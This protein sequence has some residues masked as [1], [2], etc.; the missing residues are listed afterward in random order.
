[1]NT[2]EATEV[3]D[4][5]VWKSLVNLLAVPT[6][7]YDYATHR[8]VWG[9]SAAMDFFHSSVADFTASQL[10]RMEQAHN[11]FIEAWKAMNLQLRQ[12]VEVYGLELTLEISCKEVVPGVLPIPKPLAGGQALVK[13][14]KVRDGA[15]VHTYM[16]F[17]VLN[18]TEAYHLEDNHLRMVE[19]CDNHPM[20]QFLLDRQGLILAANKRALG[21]LREHLGS[22][23]EYTFQM[24]LSI[25]ECDGS[26]AA[27]VVFKEAQAA[28]YEQG[29]PCYRFR[30]LRWS[31]RHPGKFRWVLYE[32]WPLPDP[33]TKLKSMLVTE[34]NIS[35]FIA[36]EQT[37]R[38]QNNRLKAQLEEALT[39]RSHQPSIDID[40]PADKTLKFLDKLIQGDEVSPRE[41]FDLRD[42]ILHAADLL[43]PVNFSEQL[44]K[45]N[46]SVL[47]TEVSQ[48]LIQLLSSRRSIQVEEAQPHAHAPARVARA[49]VSLEAVSS[50]LALQRNLPDAV[51]VVLSKVD[52]WQFDSFQ[53]NVVSGGRPLS[54]LAFALLK[55]SGLVETF[56]LDEEKLVKFLMLVEDGY[57]QNPYHN[58]IHAADVLRSLHVLL[59]RGG[60]IEAGYCENQVLL[61]CYLS[62]IIHDYQH[63][64]V[65]NDF[66]V[67]SMDDLAV[68]YNDRS[69]MENHHL[70]ASFNLMQTDECNF[71][72]R[73]PPKTR[74]MTRKLT[75]DMVLAT[76]MKQHFSIH[77]MF[78]AKMH[79]HA[80]TNNSSQHTNYHA[81]PPSDEDQRSIALQ[82]T[83]KC[84]D[85]GH[86][87][88]PRAVHREWVQHLEEEFFRQGDREKQHGLAVS[89]LMDRE[90]SGVTKSQVGFIDIVALPLFQSFAHVFQGAMP[91]LEAVKDNYA[92][93]KE[94]A[95]ATPNN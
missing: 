31:K 8:N 95:M 37:F 4:L 47:D 73:M 24:Y 58:R 48:N 13:P 27:D 81:P 64:G 65:N 59:S 35:E 72:K 45:T 9:N 49:D 55:R 16:L 77:S 10:D 61:A 89:P 52:E 86:L 34:Q 76:D 32:M 67:R 80:V 22:H 29:Q 15:G 23:E 93:W 57:P 83:L 42:A 21:N 91:L 68:L 53:L 17:Q 94:E 75:I 92:M 6:W 30:Q 71:W 46:Q 44:M 62:A 5:E 56:E 7:I 87:A 1:M 43:Q 41:A 54:M 69:P 3:L 12:Q 20:L 63:K 36:Q 33:V 50:L 14:A 74:E 51:T 26:V 38:R 39:E 88:S 25:G 11:G 28:V 18:H 60:L 82:V 84:A 90:K 70:A 78:Q 79:V 40:T 2:D 66:L 85:L 19:M